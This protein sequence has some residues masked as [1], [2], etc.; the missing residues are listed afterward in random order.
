MISKQ[1]EEFD[2]VIA[3]AGMVGASLACLLE[4]TP[5]RIALIDQ[6]PVNSGEI[7]FDKAQPKFDPRVSAF[8]K[9][10][11]Q[12]FI[13][14]G[15]W[16]DIAGKRS[17]SYQDMQVW[18]AQGTGSIHFSAADI[19][20]TELGTIVENSIVTTALH[21]KLVKLE[22]LQVLP[23][24]TIEKLQQI[25][26]N[27]EQFLQLE[28]S[29]GDTLHTRLLVAADGAN[30][31]IRELA[32]F[33]TKEWDYNHQALVTTVRTEKAHS[34]TARQC[35]LETGPLAFLP[36]SPEAD[37]DDQ[38]FCSIVW[39]MVPEKAEEVM[40][41]TDDQFKIQLALAL[42]QELGAVEWVDQRFIFPLRQRH[43]T[44][45]VKDNIVLVGDAAH[46]IHPLAGQGVNLGLLDVKALAEELVRGIE[47]GRE[48]SDVTVLHRYQRQRI[49]HNLG[50]MWLMEGFKHLF[51]QQNLTARWLRNIGMNS[52]NNVSILKNQLARRAMGL[53]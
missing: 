29:A 17:C 18:D 14:L 5:L 42:E 9:A 37:S 32:N 21:A 11:K 7:F 12:L 41:L 45:Y 48:I 35:F 3:G 44:D 52:V 24:F 28:S 22:N 36:L 19:N 50:M 26:L 46:T 27:G 4:N 20:Q 40:A 30:S 6:L 49:G 38:H 47:A 23:P 10:S 13:E 34:N 43:A 25:R 8:T 1:P 53:D 39:S 51:A 33:A 16:Q 2:V 15:V 31:K